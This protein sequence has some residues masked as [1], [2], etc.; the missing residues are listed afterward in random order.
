MRSHK[1]A[2]KVGSSW[3][4]LGSRIGLAGPSPACA[5]IAFDL[6][7]LTV[8]PDVIGDPCTLYGARR[9][10][11]IESRPMKRALLAVGI[12]VTREFDLQ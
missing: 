7:T 3:Q 8:R 5:R 4:F 11:I 12:A 10:G 6:Q 9:R 2:R 1:L